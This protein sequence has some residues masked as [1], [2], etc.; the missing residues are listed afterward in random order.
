MISLRPVYN[1]LCSFLLMFLMMLM[2]FSLT[3]HY[4]VL[5]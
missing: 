1:I 5:L 3:V 4:A 2:M